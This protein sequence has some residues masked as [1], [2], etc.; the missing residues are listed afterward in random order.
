MF[1]EQLTPVEKLYRTY[2][3]SLK[4]MPYRSKVTFLA[5]LSRNLLWGNIQDS[6]N[7]VNPNI[8]QDDPAVVQW[9]ECIHAE[10]DAEHIDFLIEELSQQLRQ[11]H[12]VPDPP[13]QNSQPDGWFDPACFFE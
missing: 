12:Y 8:W 2:G 9:I 6:I 7:A 11:G 13:R 3:E 4:T 10:C 1:A 5:A